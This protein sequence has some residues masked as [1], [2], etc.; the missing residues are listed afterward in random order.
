D[1]AV[2]AAR[3][4]RPGPGVP[5]T[6]AARA[7]R[8]GRPARRYRLSRAR[9]APA[10]AAT[11]PGT[12]GP[13]LGGCRLPGT[14]AACCPAHPAGSARR[15]RRSGDR[16][17]PGRGQPADA[18]RAARHCGGRCAAA[19]ADALQPAGPGGGTGGAA[20]ACSPWSGCG[21]VAAGRSHARRDRGAGVPARWGRSALGP[22]PGATQL[23][24][25][26]PLVPHPTGAERSILRR[27][28]GLTPRRRAFGYGCR[29]AAFGCPGAVR[30]LGRMTGRVR[31]RGRALAR[32]ASPAALVGVGLAWSVLT[33]LLSSAPRP[34]T[35]AD[36][37]GASG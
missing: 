32:P 24:L 3:C 15:R 29:A 17:D 7:D 5:G 2:L 14:P 18:G 19:V 13:H 23:L 16:V 10:P 34:A 22:V 37:T 4:G 9:A 33:V 30:I 28:S 27:V 6:G 31:A 25:L 26:T 35:C 1:L 36:A 11:R 12:V 8:A 21:V 20:G